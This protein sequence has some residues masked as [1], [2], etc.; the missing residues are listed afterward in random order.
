MNLDQEPQRIAA[1]IRQIL[2]NASGVSDEIQA[3]LARY[4]HPNEQLS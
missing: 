2:D 3:S 4:M 1:E